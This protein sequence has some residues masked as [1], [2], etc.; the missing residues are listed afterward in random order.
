MSQSFESV[1]SIIAARK[2]L[3]KSKRNKRLIL[4]LTFLLIYSVLTSV[5][6][7]MYR[8]DRLKFSGISWKNH[9]YL[10]ESELDALVDLKP[11]I[12][13]N[14]PNQSLI[15]LESHPLIESVILTDIG[16]DT[17]T[18][19]LVEHDVLA[20]LNDNPMTWLLENGDI[21]SSKTAFLEGPNISGYAI[22]D[23]DKITKALNSLDKSTLLAID[24]IIREAQTYDALYARIYMQD[25]IQ[26]LS[27]FKG[28][29][30]LNDYASIVSAMNPE[31]RCMS[32]DEI[33]L[34]P[35]SFP[36]TQALE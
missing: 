15:K 3:K 36:C 2:K 32:I 35:Y 10:S 29:V 30:V 22:K 23:Y 26:V 1:E 16:L 11:Y 12:F 18:I 34:V 24:E 5:F 20:T 19:T 33:R 31:H 25:G 27:G 7:L 9:Q 13:Q 4:I 8:F 6:F 14:S 21:Y 28:L 17:W